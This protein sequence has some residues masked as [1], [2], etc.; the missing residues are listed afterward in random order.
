MQDR[1]VTPVP[2]EWRVL[3]FDG[4]DPEDPRWIIATVTLA[5][6]V[7]PAVPSPKMPALPITGSGAFPDWAEVRNWVKTQVGHTV[8]L[9]PIAAQVWDISAIRGTP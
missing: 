7:A 8:A 6:D 4:H 2:H 5:T 1:S 9:T 3:I